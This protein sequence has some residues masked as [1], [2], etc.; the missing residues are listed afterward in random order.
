MTG[1]ARLE[2]V[3]DEFPVVDVSATTPE[4][5]VGMAGFYLALII[6]DLIF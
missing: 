3:Q 2:K 4:A 1:L 5:V 6:L